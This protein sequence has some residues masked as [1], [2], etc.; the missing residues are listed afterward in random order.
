L[1]F[2]ASVPNAFIMEYCVE[3]SEISRALAKNPIPIVDGRATVAEEPGLGVEP[4]PAIIEKY[5]VRD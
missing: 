3:P 1:H 4:N 5:L 2:L